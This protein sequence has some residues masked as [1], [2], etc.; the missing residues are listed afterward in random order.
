VI[1]IHVFYT[2]WVLMIKLGCFV[3]V[4][5]DQTHKESAS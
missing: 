2:Q 4:G 3:F 1:G 5:H